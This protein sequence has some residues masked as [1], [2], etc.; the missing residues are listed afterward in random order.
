MLNAKRFAR[1]D[2]SK[3][4]QVFGFFSTEIMGCICS[5]EASVDEYVDYNEREKEKEKELNKDS[6]QLV[7]P[8]TGEEFVMGP[9]GGGGH[10]R[11]GGSV[12]PISKSALQGNVGSAPIRAMEGEKKAMTADRPTK[13]S[14]QRR[15]TLD[16]ENNVGP[17]PMSRIVSMPNGAKGEQIV[18]GWPSWLSSVAG[19]A[20]Q[21]WVPLRPESY[22]KLDKVSSYLASLFVSF[23]ATYVL[24]DYGSVC[25]CVHNCGLFLHIAC[26]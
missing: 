25:I 22:E 1:C 21:G 8:S 14:H 12:H 16:M 19:E 10:G 23:D 15:L 4:W 18:A 26:N 9:G 24:F 11:T 3:F 17:S 20:I 7:A 2:C 6:V 13:A 5:K